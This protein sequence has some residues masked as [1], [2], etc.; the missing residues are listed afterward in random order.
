VKEKKDAGEKQGALRA[1]QRSTFNVQRSTSNEGETCQRAFDLEERLLEYA[2]R[3]IRLVDSLHKTRAANH[4]GGQLLRSGTSPLPNHGEAQA[5]ESREDFIHKL[6]I[7]LK[8]LRETR[9]WLRLI[10]RVPLIS[11]PGKLEDLLSETEELIR[12]FDRSIRTAK[13]NSAVSSV[14]EDATPDPW[15][16][17]VERWKLNVEPPAGPV[18]YKAAP[19]KPRRCLPKR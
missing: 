6:K 14:R 13:A 7:C 8:E 10:E 15:A 11:K 16:L 19:R 4:V 1:A 3:I 12:I 2:S 9:R 5:A 18:D 17:E